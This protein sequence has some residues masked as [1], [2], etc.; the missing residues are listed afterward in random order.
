MGRLVSKAAL[1]V[2]IC[3]LIQGSGIPGSAGAA[4]SAIK[5]RPVPRETMKREGR[6]PDPAAAAA[7][8][9]VSY[10]DRTVVVG[11]WDA[12]WGPVRGVSVSGTTAYLVEEGYPPHAAND[13]IVKVVDTTNPARPAILGKVRFGILVYQDFVNDTVLSGS[14]L[15]VNLPGGI[16]IVD[17]S[18][19]TAPALVGSYMT[20]SGTGLAVSGNHA[21]VATY[22]GL[23][24]LDISNP[25]AP[26]QVGSLPM[27]ALRVAVSG[28]YAYLIS[29]EQVQI[30]NVSD[31]AAPESLGSYPLPSYPRDLAVAGDYLD[32][33]GDFGLVVLD[34]SDPSAPFQAYGPSQPYGERIA[35]SGAHAYVGSSGQIT[36]L[37]L[38]TPSYPSRAGAYSTEDIG[39]T[40]Q[41]AVSGSRAYS[42][43]TGAGLRI[44]D[45]SNP[46]V[47]VE[48]GAL[49]QGTSTEVTVVGSHAYVAEHY[50][51]LRILDV[52]MPGAPA[53]VG[54]ID[55]P[56]YAEQVAVSGSYAFVADGYHG[57]RVID[58]SDPASPVEAG[59]YDTGTGFATYI[60][61]S[62]TYAY[63]SDAG[64]IRILDIS[65]PPQPRLVGTY[66]PAD[67]SGYAVSFGKVVL[68]GSHLF[69]AS[70]TGLTILDVSNPFAPVQVGTYPL[71]FALDVDVSGS[72]AYVSDADDYLHILDVSDPTAPGQVGE[73][74]AFSASATVSG[75]LAY[76]R[77]IAYETYE[78][79]LGILDVSNPSACTAAGYLLGFNPGPMAVSNS[80]IYAPAGAEGVYVVARDADRD[81]IPDPTDACPESIVTPDIM[82]GTCD[83]GVPNTI[84]PTGCS[85]AD[86]LAAC[87]D[88]GVP[89][90]QQTACLARALNHLERE[91]AI[92]PGQEG[93]IQRCPAKTS[94]P[95]CRIRGTFY[96]AE[97]RNPANNCQACLPDVNGTDWT[98]LPDYDYCEDGN[99]CTWGDLCVSG[100]CVPG[101]PADCDDNDVCTG[102]SCD[103]TSGACTHVPVCTGG[104]RSRALPGR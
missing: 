49:D 67:F 55:T 46:A 48:L 84:F 87:D 76:V 70:A 53:E 45:V 79:G 58:V 103:P 98:T 35:I 57:L 23:L 104:S 90:G 63:L 44:V 52:S 68:S 10:I 69:F 99:L 71:R 92:T 21:Y 65:N 17:V 56:G 59:A 72:L 8:D 37:D 9:S 14:H 54:S 77:L 12:G 1:V 13:I 30:V 19:P 83:T 27:R 3:M 11:H 97:E 96:L 50:G 5:P 36:V 89:A 88:P 4:P 32:V 34:V 2:A 101:P 38:S 86:R 75:G 16:E 22:N 7:P 82:A 40:A 61:I 66:A 64:F 25:A 33:V 85:I 100:A 29:Q 28:S 51:G 24:I 60:L 20:R 6:Q 62:G 47:P 91:G 80:Y 95:G 39:T 31:P 73:C 15:F 102:D 41:I 81:G 94:A 42:A 93:R 26:V 18:D 43:S 78:D 74:L